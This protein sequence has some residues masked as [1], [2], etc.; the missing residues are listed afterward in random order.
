MCV[1]VIISSYL[2]N[3]LV[4]EY[5]STNRAFSDDLRM[6]MMISKAHFRKYFLLADRLNGTAEI[7][8]QQSEP[9]GTSSDNMAPSANEASGP[10]HQ[11]QLFRVGFEAAARESRHDLLLGSDLNQRVEFQRFCA[12]WRSRDKARAQRLMALMPQGTDYWKFNEGEQVRALCMISYP[13]I[14]TSR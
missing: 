8:R 3:S 10:I 14:N 9:H 4:K 7:I 12:N 11:G 6:D 2:H 5:G 1:S 13:S